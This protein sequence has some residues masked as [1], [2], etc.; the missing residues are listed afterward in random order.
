MAYCK[1]VN[2]YSFWFNLLW[3]KSGLNS[4]RAITIC[5]V[6]LLSGCQAVT[7]PVANGIP[8]RLLSN[9][10][11]ANSR[12]SLEPIPLKWLRQEEPEIYTLS[13]GDI[14]GIYIDGILGE[15]DELPPVTNHAGN[16]APTIGLPIAVRENGTIPLPLIEPIYVQGDTIAEVEK[17]IIDAYTVTDPILQ[18]SRTRILVSLF[19]K[20]TIRIHVIRQDSAANG[21]QQNNIRGPLTRSGPDLSN[22][23]NDTRG[24]AIVLDLPAYENDLLNALTRSG[25]L[26]GLDAVNKVEIHHKIRN[27]DAT[28]AAS[29]IEVTHIPLRVWPGQQKPFQS[30]DIIL[31]NGDIVFIKRRDDDYY[32]TSG[33]LANRKVLLPR[34]YDVR[35]I[36]AIVESGGPLIN[37]SFTSN[38]L[39]GS[40]SGSGLGTPNPSLL[41]I[42]RRLP[43]GRQFN[44]QVDL[45]RAILDPRENIILQKNDLLIMQETPEEAYT[46]Y[47]SSVL[48]FNVFGRFL[49]EDDATGSGTIRLP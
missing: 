22:R 30:D 36:E 1:T 29:S 46:R 28:D 33:L 3:L 25:G 8:V 27:S 7:N 18:R 21:Q 49:N 24:S 37:G 44:I 47:I 13:S 26:P 48:Q 39:S 42:I 41:S 45:N 32:Y 17:K 10:L 15:K 31:K 20:R 34:D 5:S 23:T 9:E 16:A 12:S 43:D 2:L 35:V 4:T 6:I 38:N 19:Q 14:L 11:L 40:I